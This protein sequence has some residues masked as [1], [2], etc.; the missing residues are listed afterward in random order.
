M[1]EVSAGSLKLTIAYDGAAFSGSQKQANARTVQEE[2]EGV[3]T[4]LEGS[5][6]ATTFAGRT[7]RGVHA[8]GQVAS[9]ADIRPGMSDER[10][11]RAIDALLP[12]DIGL[13]S[14]ERRGVPFNA[15]FD[16]RWREYRYRIWVGQRQPLTRAMCWQRRMPL[17][18]EAMHRAAGSLVGTHDL[19]TFTGAGDG[20][21][22]SKRAASARGTVRTIRA[23]S[24]APFD[25]WAGWTHGPGAGI[26]IRMVADGFLPHLVRNVVGALVEIGAGKRSASWMAD[27]LAAEDRRH[28]P[29][30]APPQGL[31]LWRVGYDAAPLRRGRKISS[32]C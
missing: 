10:L 3:L 19:A 6:V 27:L 31:I 20:V 29:A 23:S 12:E 2:L 11:I 30:P 26:E 22:W 9:C 4:R 21:P 32:G 8:L 18:V 24:V 5:P 25:G 28:A 15:R 1:E 16:A 13:V 7:D 14:L 17:D